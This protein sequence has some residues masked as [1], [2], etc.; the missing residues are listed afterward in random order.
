MNEAYTD[1]TSTCAPK[2]GANWEMCTK[3]CGPPGC[4]CLPGYFRNADNICVPHA[5]CTT[6]SN[7]SCGTNEEYTP[8]SGCEKKCF[9]TITRCAKVCGPPKCQCRDNYFRH[10]N[11]SC[12]AKE[13]CNATTT[14]NPRNPLPHFNPRPNGTAPTPPMICAANEYYTNC[15]SSCEPRCNGTK[16][17]CDKTCGP[18]GCQ[19]L[20]GYFRADDNGCVSR[21]QCGSTGTTSCGMNEQHSICSGCEKQCSGVRSNLRFKES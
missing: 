1:C 7:T 4:E 15:T 8:C 6:S 12:V 20:P 10:L 11:G 18:P 3:E 13:Y 16:D 17:I 2:C 5:K 14:F 9:G 21:R 19:C